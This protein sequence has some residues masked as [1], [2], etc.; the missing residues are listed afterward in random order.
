MDNKLNHASIDAYSA[1]YAKKIAQHYF[2]N[3]EVI[4]GKQILSLCNIKQTNL[5]IIKN[6]FQKWK[7]ETEKLQSPYFDYDEPEVVTALNNFMNV[8]S[9]NIAIKRNNF[10]PL[11]KKAVQ[12]TILLIF[13]P[14]DYYSLEINNPEKTRVS[15]ADLEE[16]RNYIKINPHLLQSL[17]ARF[18]DDAIDEVFNDEGFSILN[19]INEENKDMPE[20]Y[21]PYLEKFSQTI[22]L[23]LNSIYM[24]STQ[25]NEDEDYALLQPKFHVKEQKEP[26][27]KQIHENFFSK[28]ETVND[29]LT[30][31][32]APKFTIADIH[33][34]KKI[35]SIKQNISINQKFMFIKEL[36]QGNAGDFNKALE[37]L[38]ALSSYDVALRFLNDKYA[39]Q[40]KWD[41]ESEEVLEFLDVVS[42]KFQ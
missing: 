19:E 16:I 36:F 26:P 2:L 4:K 18:K 9:Q 24:E 7:K 34:K 14:Y 32:A 6:L 5:F 22:P 21:N 20:D 38:E 1:S 42:K 15:L 17:I 23:A 27:K 10:E 12:E 39:R 8:L 33:L 31:Q 41:M 37:A 11:L 35:D 13:S 29:K 30:T 25:E 3:E 40:Y 28:F